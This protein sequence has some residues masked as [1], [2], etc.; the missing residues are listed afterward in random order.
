MKIFFH[1]CGVHTE[2]ANFTSLLNF[3][4]FF[5]VHSFCR[6][7]GITEKYIAWLSTKIE[8]G[9]MG[10]DDQHFKGDYVEW[11]RGMKRASA[12]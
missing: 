4:W 1:G 12:E 10:H 6:I 9:R 8:L 7:E 3:L 5:F 2:K 11:E